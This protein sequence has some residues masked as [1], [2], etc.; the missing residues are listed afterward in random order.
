VLLRPALFIEGPQQ[1][2]LS[3]GRLMVRRG[4]RGCGLP[5]GIGVAAGTA[6]GMLRILAGTPLHWYMIVGDIV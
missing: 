4:R 2:L 1:A 3:P 5:R 6:C